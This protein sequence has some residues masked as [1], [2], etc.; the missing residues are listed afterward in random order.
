MV[1]GSIVIQISS[2]RVCMCVCVWRMER[3]EGLRKKPI[4]SKS[5]LTISDIGLKCNRKTKL[6]QMSV[7]KYAQISLRMYKNKKY[8]EMQ[9]SGG[10][11]SLH[12]LIVGF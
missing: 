8:D 1:S 7:Q 10:F 9:K 11:N 4:I 2:N 3:G 12:K 6:C 5:L